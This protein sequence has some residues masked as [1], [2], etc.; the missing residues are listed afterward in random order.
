ME[1]IAAICPNCGVAKGIGSNYCP[2]CGAPVELNASAKCLYCGS[3]ITA[4]SQTF[5]LNGIRGISQKTG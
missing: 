2:N 1:D 4:E 5:V 3:I